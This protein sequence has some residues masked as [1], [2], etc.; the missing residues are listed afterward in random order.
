M[1]QNQEESGSH[2][3]G[4]KAGTPGKTRKYPE[5]SGKFPSLHHLTLPM[6]ATTQRQIQQ[7]QE[8]SGNHRKN[9]ARSGK[10]VTRSFKLKTH[11][12]RSPLLRRKSI[13]LGRSS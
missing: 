8:M 13:G 5:K 4:S 1:A 12:R 6:H 2:F 3:I 11:P 9:L 10:M 7:S